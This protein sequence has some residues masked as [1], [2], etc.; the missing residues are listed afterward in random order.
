MAGGTW[1]AQNKVRAGAYINFKDV[2]KPLSTLGIRGVMTMPVAMSWGATITELLSS[3]LLDGK[4]LAKIGYTAFDDESQIFREALKN[5]YKAIIYRLDTGGVKAAATLGVLTATAKYAGKVGND[6]SVQIIANGSTFD[7][8]TLY[9]DVQRDKQTGATTVS[10]LVNNE[11]VDFT[12][13]GSLAA[14]AGVDLAAG[15]DGTISDATYATYFATLQAY[16]WNTMAIPQDNATA[17]A[18]ALAFITSMRETY[19]KK[20]QCVLFNDTTADYEGIIN[21]V[22]GYKTVFEEISP[23]TFTAYVAGLTAGSEV[24]KSN[25]YHEIS[26]ATSITYPSGVLPYTEEDI[27]EALEAGKF[28]LSTRQDGAVVVEKDINT[29]HT[30]T[31]DKGYVFSKN[32]VVRTLDEINNSIS[33][34]FEKSY[35]GKVDNNDDG[36]N[37]FKADVI[38]YLTN[39]QNIAAIQNFNAATDITIY[40]GEDID[41]V[42]VDLAV[43]PVDSMEK[44][45]MTVMVG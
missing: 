22:Q 12:G 16:K 1:T 28:I 19:G 13:T 3:D 30:F 42:V 27:L 26:G 35:I 38:N 15:A 44:L 17:R 24:D 18:G 34:L 14:N 4:S 8:I 10:D 2:G 37:I 9:K 23:E 41:S 36:R 43:Q 33:L 40:A 5:C 32:R 11:W 31:N 21:V 20:T 45:Y 25:T 6:I 7:V 29:L 39:L